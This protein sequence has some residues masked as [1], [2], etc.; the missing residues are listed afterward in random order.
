M[1]NQLKDTTSYNI[2]VCVHNCSALNEVGTYVLSK[3]S[4]SYSSLFAVTR[5]VGEVVEVERLS[6]ILSR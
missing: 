3:H 4:S 5:S 1:N 2:S 6:F